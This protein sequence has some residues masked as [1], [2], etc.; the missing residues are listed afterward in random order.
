MTNRQLFGLVGSIVLFIGVFTPLASSPPFSFL[1]DMD[2]F[3]VVKGK[4]DA[5]FI[6]GLSLISLLL[7][8][9]KKYR[10]LLITGMLSLILI[11]FDIVRIN[12][13]LELRWGWAFLFFGTFFII[14]AGVIKSNKIKCPFCLE[15]IKNEARV[16]RYCGKEVIVSEKK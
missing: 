11:V 10:G 1:G 9:A 8:I 6:M 14:I 16:C 5:F 15:L 13:L 12:K 4:D 7:T 2:L 3:T